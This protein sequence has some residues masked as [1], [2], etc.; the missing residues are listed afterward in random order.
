[1]INSNNSNR[2]AGEN[3][4]DRVVEQI[5]IPSLSNQY[6]G[7]VLAVDFDSPQQNTNFLGE[8]YPTIDYLGTGTSDA[9]PLPLE[10]STAVGDS[11]G[12]VLTNFE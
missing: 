9:N 10:V 11:G 7:G 5:S 6:W 8:E 2:L 3:I 12:P 4:L 1:M